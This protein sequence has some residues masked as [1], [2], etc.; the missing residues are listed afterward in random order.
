VSEF[1]SYSGRILSRPQPIG[2][3][4]HW[5]FLRGIGGISW[6]EFNPPPEWFP[7]RAKDNWME[8]TEV[9][10]K[11]TSTPHLPYEIKDLW[12]QR[13]GICGSFA[14]L[15]S[16]PFFSSRAYNF[17]MSESQVSSKFNC[18][19]TPLQINTSEH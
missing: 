10:T 8:E 9:S 16:Q 11:S 17:G 6:N 19:A 15:V 5:W 14:T 3:I 7:Q 1:K 12:F 4:A 13:R 18:H 2:G